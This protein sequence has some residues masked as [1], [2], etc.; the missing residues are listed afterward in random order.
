MLTDD[1]RETIV[2]AHAVNRLLFLALLVSLIMY[3]I[4]A[5]AVGQ[6]QTP[7]PSQQT[8]MTLV[9]AMIAVVCVGSGQMLRTLVL[10]RAKGQDATAATA[11][12]RTAVI[13]ALAMAE[14]AGLMGFVLYLLGWGNGPMLALFMALAAVSMW[15][16]RPRLDELQALLEKA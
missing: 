4:V 1:Q 6:T 9:F 3:A 10:R 13:I 12:Y 16:F 5:V 15:F 7:D 8:L 14:A 11:T 2:K